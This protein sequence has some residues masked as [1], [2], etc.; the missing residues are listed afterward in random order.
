MLRSEPE[1]DGHVSTPQP[2]SFH[3]SHVVLYMSTR[4]YTL[5]YNRWRYA[6][7][8]F[9][10]KKKMKKSCNLHQLHMSLQCRKKQSKSQDPK[11]RQWNTY[12]YRSFGDNVNSDPLVCFYRTSSAL[13]VRVQRM[14][15]VLR[16]YAGMQNSSPFLCFG[17][18]HFS[19]LKRS[20]PEC[21]WAVLHRPPFQ[22]GSGTAPRYE[23]TVFTLIKQ[24][25]L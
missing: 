25:G 6:P 3:S 11:P 20:V 8:W 18:Q 5:L 1:Y 14:R 23:S 13:A 16:P 4:I 22:V 9:N 10:V 7:G 2:L 15:L 12:C 19:H 21:T 17:T 24:T